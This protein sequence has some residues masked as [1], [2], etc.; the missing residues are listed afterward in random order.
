VWS[1]QLPLNGLTMLAKEEV[2]TTRLTVG[3]DFLM[4]L[5]TPVVPI[6]AGSRSSLDLSVRI[7]EEK[8]EKDTG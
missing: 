6:M 2:M 5:R 3:A 4:D 1:G 8:R 7:W